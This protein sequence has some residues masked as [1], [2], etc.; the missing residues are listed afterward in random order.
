MLNPFYN[1][2][3]KS[4]NPNPVA[5]S[6]VRGILDKEEGLYGKV[7]RSLSRKLSLMA[8]RPINRGDKQQ[9]ALPVVFIKLFLIFVS[10][11]EE[12]TFL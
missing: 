5:S 12:L 1:K 11:D 10:C 4:K 3:D 7:G 2:F 6:P 9:L 8:N